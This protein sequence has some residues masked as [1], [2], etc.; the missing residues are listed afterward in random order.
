MISNELA[1]IRDDMNGLKAIHK[2]CFIQRKVFEKIRCKI[3]TIHHALSPHIVTLCVYKLIER[4]EFKFPFE[5]NKKFDSFF[6]I[7][8]LDNFQNYYLYV[9]F[10]KY[11]STTNY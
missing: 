4:I 2:S 9:F 11:R 8:N 6:F 7:L 3:H 10:I 5:K 1:L